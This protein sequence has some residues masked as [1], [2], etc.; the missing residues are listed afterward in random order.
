M[1]QLHAH[2]PLK[3][4]DATTRVSTAH[5]PRVHPGGRRQLSLKA[6]WRLHGNLQTLGYFAAEMCVGN[7][8]RSFLLIV[9]TGSGM[10][11]LPCADCTHCGHHSAGTRFDAAASPTSSVVGCSG[12]GSCD[13]GSCGYSVSYTEG[14]SIRGRLVRDEVH[15]AV[16]GASGRTAPTVFGCQTYES[17]LFH[18]QQ[19]DGIAGFSRA[20]SGG[21]GGSLLRDLCAATGAPAVG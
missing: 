17:G 3:F 2:T 4:V 13:R 6:G 15:Y 18:S 10:T 20:G 7:P 9:D 12:C 8:P 1:W 16:D 21:Q 11:A 5:D 19:A 14:S